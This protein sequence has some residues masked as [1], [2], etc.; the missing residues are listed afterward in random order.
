[1]VVPGGPSLSANADGSGSSPGD[2]PIASYRFD[3]GDGT[4]PVIT[5]APTATASHTYAA[6]GTYTV[7]LVVTDTGGRSSAPASVSVTV[8]ASTSG[9]L[10][11]YVGYYDT[12]H[13]DQLQAK[14]SPWYGSSGISFVGSPDP[15]TSNGWDTSGIRLDNLSSGSVT[16]SVTVD[17]G[18]DHFAL[19]GAQTIAAGRTLILAQTGYENFDGSDTNPAGCFGCDPNL[20]ITAVDKN[21]PVVHVTVGSTTTNYFDNGQVSNTN[22]VDKA[23]C[24]YTGTRN[25][26]S[27]VW[28]QIYTQAPMAAAREARQEQ[29][30]PRASAPSRRFYLGPVSPNPAGVDLVLRFEIPEHQRVQLGI[31]DVTGRLVKSHIDGEMDAG[32]FQTHIGLASIPAGMYYCRMQAGDHVL[33]QRFVHV[34]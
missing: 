13:S 31:Y 27:H 19:W 5:T 8:N 17:M 6:A 23:G 11:V 26:E 21:I 20:C 10:A 32:E 14:P 33:A 24:P 25:D 29:Q 16:A 12:H 3:F 7:T 9:P 30:A 34:R 28:T 18:S 2:S 4:A 1:M 22:G 15:G